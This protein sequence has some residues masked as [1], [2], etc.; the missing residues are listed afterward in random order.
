[1]NSDAIL[2]TLSLTN[3]S[4][5]R[6]I[7]YNWLAGVNSISNFV[8]Q[9]RKE[10]LPETYEAWL[11]PKAQGSNITRIPGAGFSTET[12]HERIYNDRDLYRN[13]YRYKSKFNI[14]PIVNYNNN[15]TE[16]TIEDIKTGGH[17][18]VKVEGTTLTETAM[19]I[20]ID[21]IRA[22]FEEY[23]LFDVVNVSFDESSFEQK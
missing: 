18:N 2:K 16:Y 4:G 1:M 5:Q 20:I 11:G 21:A 22:K 12:S 7:N 19:K 3:S 6:L 15:E 9:M 13:L 23:S 10:I 14:T 17:L 8:K